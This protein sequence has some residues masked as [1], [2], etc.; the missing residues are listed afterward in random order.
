MLGLTLTDKIGI[1]RQGTQSTDNNSLFMLF[2]GLDN[3]QSLGFKVKELFIVLLIYLLC[4]CEVN[5]HSKT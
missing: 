4:I 2:V 5:L 3:Y 1:T